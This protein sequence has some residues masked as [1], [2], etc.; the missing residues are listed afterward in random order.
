MMK[1]FM[2]ADYRGCLPLRKSIIFVVK[3]QYAKN[4]YEVLNVSKTSSKKEIKLAYYKLSKVYHPD[5]TE[6]HN[7]ENKYKEI[8]E[9]YHVLGDEKRRHEYDTSLR[10]GYYGGASSTSTS[11]STTGDFYSPGGW[12]KRSGPIHTGRTSA[13]DYDDHYRSHYGRTAQ[14]GG[15]FSQRRAKNFNNQDLNNYWNT[16]EFTGED[17]MKNMRN[18]FIFRSLYVTFFLVLIYLGL[19]TLKARE[20]EYG[21][22]AILN[23]NKIN[24]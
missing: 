13:Y 14:A 12:K 10:E 11:T 21:R 6:V 22:R 16:K 23:A 20:V 3:R 1:S 8:Q 24:K 5:V 4:Y 19:S 18:R 15:G 2:I 9:A 7:S 17:D